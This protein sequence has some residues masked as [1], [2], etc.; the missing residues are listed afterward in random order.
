VVLLS[1]VDPQPLAVTALES[2]SKEVPIDVVVFAPREEAIHFDRWGRPLADAW[3]KRV[4]DLP[5]FEQRVHLCVDPSDQARRIA[6]LIAAYKNPDNIVGLGVADAEVLTPLERA[7]TE[8]VVGVFNPEGRL[9]RGDQLEQLLMALG[10]LA[11][12]ESFA[13]VEFLARCPDL[14]FFL[15]DRLGASFSPAIFLS[16]LDDLRST[17]LPPTLG[18]AQQQAANDPALAEIEALR[19][20]LIAGEFPASAVTVLSIIFANRRFDGSVV[21]DA[22]LADAS[23]AWMAVVQEITA[24]ATEFSGLSKPDWWDV[25]LRLYAETRYYDEKPDAAVELQGWLELPW[26]DAPHLIIAGIN[27]GRVPESVSGDP[28]LPESLRQRLGLKTNAARFARDAYL[29][30]ALAR[31]RAG[32]G[33]IDLFLG[34]TSVSGDPLRPSRLLFQCADEVLADRVSFLFKP[35]EQVRTAPAWRRAWKLVPRRSNPPSQVAVTGFRQWLECPLRFYFSRVLRMKAVDPAKSEM[36]V[37]D[38]G[39]L[40]HL[41]L[42][43]MAQEPALRDCQDASELRQFLVGR[44]D[45]EVRRKYGDEL[46]LP[47]LVQV[48]AAR[49]RLSR[50]AEIQATT[51]AEGWVLMEAETPFEIEVGGL[52]V[53]GKIDR[54]D[55]HEASGDWRVV[56]YKTSDLAVDPE[57]AHWRGMR[58]NDENAPEFARFIWSGR[59]LV[60]KDLQLPLYRQAVRTRAVGANLYSGYFNL[61]KATSAGSLRIWNDYTSELDEAAWR[62]SV[63]VANSIRAGI[64]WPPNERLRPDFDLFAP[65]FHHGVADSIEW[66]DAPL[67]AMSP[68]TNAE[69]ELAP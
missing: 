64:F 41:A 34:K 32:E 43:A 26:E 40:C 33:K 27:E 30:Q 15:R 13:N 10:R 67:S 50:A 3:Q 9:R 19:K 38:F 53:V 18:C 47:L 29:L 17:Y 14:L 63:G 65:L 68:D 36:D 4:L 7:L 31:S 1:V 2:L 21:D 61:P 52:R 42:E 12:D 46:T 54:I 20:E 24:A 28:F 44:L 5:E 69:V 16:R 48:E 66:P 59:E 39:T 57:T 62:C 6:Q 37:L 23:E 22:A 58:R 35:V 45:L 56:D 55:R 11:R 60:W 8:R 25:A 51:R 49:Q